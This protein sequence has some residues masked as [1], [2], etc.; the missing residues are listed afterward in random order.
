M[1]PTGLMSKAE[2]RR[3]L[4]ALLSVALA[5][6]AAVT[7]AQTPVPTAGDVVDAEPIAELSECEDEWQDSQ[8][9][10]YCS[11][12]SVSVTQYGRCRV[13]GSCSITVSI[14]GQSTTFTP[15]IGLT[16]RARNVSNFDICFA[17]KS[18]ESSGYVAKA[19]RGC[20]SGE[21]GSST[22]TATGGLPVPGG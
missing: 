2:V 22:A 1:E 3:T 17:E 16:A 9:Y 21:T 13:S 7:R 12:A 11:E 15:S 5:A 14:G 8:A 19:R 18:S 10:Q 20:R 4:I 6:S